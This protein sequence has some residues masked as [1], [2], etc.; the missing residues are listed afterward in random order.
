MKIEITVY[1][2]TGKYYTSTIV[3]NETPIMLF[4]EDFKKF[5]A[6]NLPA[7]ISDGFVVTRNADPDSQEF[8]ERLYRTTEFKDYL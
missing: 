3:E 8:Y 5:V 4:E 6:E 7:I 2:E 1:K